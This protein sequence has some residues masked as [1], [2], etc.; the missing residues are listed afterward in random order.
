VRDFARA[1]RCVTLGDSLGFNHHHPPPCRLVPAPLALQ[2]HRHTPASPGCDA[3][4]QRSRGWPGIHK[5][6][7][8]TPSSLPCKFPLFLRFSAINQYLQVLFY[9]LGLVPD[10]NWLD[11]APRYL[12]TINNAPT[13]T[14]NPH[15]TTDSYPPTSNSRHS[16]LASYTCY[17]RSLPTPRTYHVAPDDD[18]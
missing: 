1:A 5:K 9:L 14:N 6:P 2:Q 4:R 10:E 11:F 18:E 3:R 7:G 15:R 12:Y 13:P 8:S 16:T 17:T